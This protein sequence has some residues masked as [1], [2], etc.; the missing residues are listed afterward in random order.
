[1]ITMTDIFDT[2]SDEQKSVIYALVDQTI[3]EEQEAPKVNVQLTNCPNCGAVITGPICEYCDTRFPWFD[4]SKYVSKETH[5]RLSKKLDSI[6]KF[7]RDNGLMIDGIVGPN[8][9]CAIKAQLSFGY[10]TINEAR[11]LCGLNII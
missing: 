4:E 3:H 1:M 2:F 10:I 6:S 7:Q 11:E 5:E 8:T 9:L